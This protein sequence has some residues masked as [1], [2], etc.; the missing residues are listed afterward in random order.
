M[1]LKSN[2]ENTSC[3]NTQSSLE[4]WSIAT[5]PIGPDPAPEITGACLNSYE[6]GGDAA[7]SQLLIQPTDNPATI[8]SPTPTPIP[9]IT[10]CAEERPPID[11]MLVL[12]KSGSMNNNNK[13]DK[14]NT[15]VNNF[16]DVW[17]Q[18][19]IA[20]TGD[21]LG[22]VLF[23]QEPEDWS[24]ISPGLNTFDDTLA[25]TINSAS[26]TAG[27]STSI[28]DGL[29][30]AA[31]HLTSG[32]N[33]RKVILLMSDG[34]QNTNRMAAVVPDDGD[35]D[36]PGG[37][38]PDVDGDGSTTDL[39]AVTHLRDGT[40][41]TPLPGINN[42]NIWSVSI[43][44]LGTDID[45]TIFDQ[46]ADTGTGFYINSEVPSDDLNLFFLELLQ[47]FLRFNTIE[48][49]RLVSDSIPIT[50]L[51]TGDIGSTQLKVATTSTAKTISFSLMWDKSK[52][53]N[54][55]MQITPPA[56][57]PISANDDSSNIQR[58][59]GFMRFTTALPLPAPYPKGSQIGDWTVQINVQGRGLGKRLPFQFYSLADDDI[60]K[61]KFNIKNR[62]YVTG[63]PIPL[64]ARLTEFRKPLNGQDTTLK[65]FAKLIKPED[66]IGNLLA[67][68]SAPVTDA[69]KD[70]STPSQQ[71]LD[72]LL[73][74]N[75]ALLKYSSENIPLFDDGLASHGDAVAND[76]IFN[77]LYKDTDK[78]GHYNFLFSIEGQTNASGP[79]SRQQIET[80]YVRLKPDP[81]ETIINSEFIGDGPDRLLKVTM[82]PRD[83]FGNRFGPGYANHFLISPINGKQPKFQDNNLDGVYEFTIPASADSTL[84]SL[85]IR[86]VKPFM[87]VADE[88]YPDK[89]PHSLTEAYI[90]D[91]LRDKKSSASLHLGVNFPHGSFNNDFDGDIGYALDYEY[92]WRKSSSLL[93]FIGQNKFDHPTINLDITNLSINIKHYY[94]P[95]AIGSLRYFLNAGVGYY[96]AD[97]GDNDPGL[98]IGGGAQYPI[99][100]NYGLEGW[101]NYH[102]ISSS[103]KVK[104]STLQFGLYYRF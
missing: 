97:P 24:A 84:P 73:Q 17:N 55:S 43:G 62:D 104:F 91:G 98:N 93:L 78:Q 30:S 72:A 102:Y 75:P 25:T 94:N 50:R 81:E 48:T 20:E 47:N 1:E 37:F 15:A 32:T 68:N 10:P 92:R 67:D 49:T 52:D 34:K 6:P 7:C 65:V 61:G 2:W 16:V 13:I 58:G 38:G 99:D 100:R 51:A 54:F 21:K 39:I 87:H 90:K 82:I 19:G 57:E 44:A 71:K 4:L 29:E 85:D 103:P 64:Q 60:V 18:A 69:P 89:I 80:V 63:D 56:G 46:L 27:G 3:T 41:F 74:K 23:N 9:T 96:K 88:M 83:R 14:L 95:P 31:T 101:Y 8:N 11:V 33:T 26:I 40:D 22:A 66:G 76:G 59:P 35:F 53:A 28:G 12:D 70:T 79:I 36:G 5:L 42:L 86:Y 77:N 45:P